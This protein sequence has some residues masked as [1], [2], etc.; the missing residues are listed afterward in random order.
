MVH[1]FIADTDEKAQALCRQ[2]GPLHFQQ[3]IVHYE[4][5]KAN[6]DGIQGLREFQPHDGDHS[7]SSPI[8]PRSTHG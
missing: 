8:Q 7:G 5:G 1:L 6:Y 4:I 2:Y 3:Q